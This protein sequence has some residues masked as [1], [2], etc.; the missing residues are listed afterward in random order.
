MMGHDPVAVTALPGPAV[1][2]LG[3]PTS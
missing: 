1:T 2:E 3:G